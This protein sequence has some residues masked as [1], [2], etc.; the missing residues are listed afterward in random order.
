MK[1]QI[2]KTIVFVLVMGFMSYSSM[3][4]NKNKEPM[5]VSNAFS[6]KYPAAKLK[7]WKMRN[8]TCIAMFNMDKRHY[9]A[10][11]TTNG[12]W[13]KTERNVKHLSTLPMPTQVYLKHSKYASWHIDNLAKVQTPMH[14]IYMVQLD[15]HSGNTSYENVG[16][17]ETE[18]LYFN[19][20]G[21]LVA[22]NRQ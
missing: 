16:S 12:T 14:N 13:I 5:A 21:D 6:A 2:V 22:A 11:Y 10:F 15:N 9:R 7:N 20:K 8:D 19:S 1:N 4:Q 18:N 3:A 17:D